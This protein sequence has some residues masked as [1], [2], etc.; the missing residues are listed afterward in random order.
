MDEKI[1]RKTIDLKLHPAWAQPGGLWLSHDEYDDL[2]DMSSEVLI[3]GL[4]LAEE[5]VILKLTQRQLTLEQF[6]EAVLRAVTERKGCKLWQHIVRE[7]AD[8]LCGLQA[9]DSRGGLHDFGKGS[10]V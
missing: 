4:A 5:F 8:D 3:S 2:K 1:N 10:C 6:R 7:Y 9:Q